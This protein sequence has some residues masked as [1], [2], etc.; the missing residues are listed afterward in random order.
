[1]NKKWGSWYRIY[2]VRI[3]GK[4]LMS[5]LHVRNKRQK[6][7]F[8]ALDNAKECWLDLLQKSFSYS[9][10][11]FNY[12]CQA[13]NAKFVSTVLNIWND[14]RLFQMFCKRY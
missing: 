13:F 8:A 1:M 5:H 11:P 9:I 12:A 4:P 2:S 7:E 3:V 6:K 14:M 10:T